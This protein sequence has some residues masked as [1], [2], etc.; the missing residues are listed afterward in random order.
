MVYHIIKP[1][2]KPPIPYVKTDQVLS[3][4]QN[5]IDKTPVMPSVL[6]KAEM[7]FNGILT[8]TTDQHM[9]VSNYVE[10]MIYDTGLNDGT[11]PNR[12]LDV[13][14]YDV[15]G[16]AAQI[17]TLLDSLASVWP[18]CQAVDLNVQSDAQ[19]I[20]IT[21]A[22]LEQVK[23]LVVE[24]STEMF[25]RLASRYASANLKKDPMVAAAEG[26]LENEFAPLRPPL[27]TG[28][29]KLPDSA[30][31]GDAEIELKI[32]IKRAMD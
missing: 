10:K 12:T 28:R 3:E 24:D 27:L 6:V 11:L 5:D 9:T 7:P 13:T 8:F 1:P 22:R 32:Y 21:Q 2:A 26:S 19:N 30:A 14:S 16:S 23:T 20:E 25:N 31:G 17:T 4:Q 18:R 29:N 15:T